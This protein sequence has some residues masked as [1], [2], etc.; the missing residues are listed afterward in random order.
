MVFSAFIIQQHI[1]I[2]DL[3]YENEQWVKNMFTQTYMIFTVDI[4]K[5][6][7]TSFWKWFCGRSMSTSW[8]SENAELNE[9][10]ET[11]T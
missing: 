5:H 3:S 7:E 6:H 2:V 8:R 4:L 10:N 11:T 9:T 1:Q